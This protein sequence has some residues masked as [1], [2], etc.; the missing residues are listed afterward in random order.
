MYIKKFKDFLFEVRDKAVV[1]A[2]D[3]VDNEKRDE[4]R[5]KKAEKY[6]EKETENCARCGEL[7][8][9]CVCPSEDYWSTQNYHRAPKLK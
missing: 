8:K 4:K 1:H 7:Y 6:L 5:E 9:D 2:G 3:D